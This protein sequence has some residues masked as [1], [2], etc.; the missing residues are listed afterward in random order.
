M[1]SGLNSLLLQEVDRVF[2]LIKETNA[3]LAN[4]HVYCCTER[5]LSRCLDGREV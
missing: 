1:L 3:G 5:K 4:P 2:F